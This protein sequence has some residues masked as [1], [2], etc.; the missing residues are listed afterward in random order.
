MIDIGD[1]IGPYRITSLIGTGGMGRVYEVEHCVTK[2]IEA[3]KLLLPSADGAT[4]EDQQE[5]VSRFL[6]EIQVQAS[7]AHPNIAAVHHAFVE[8]GLL[9]MVMEMVRGSSLKRLIEIDPPPVNRAVDYVAQVLGAL[10]YAH[11]RGVIH[12]DIT[13]ANIIVTTDGVAKLTDFGLAKSQKDVQITRDGV[14][15]GSVHYMSPE[16]VRGQQEL[17][18]RS[19]LYS[20][21]AVLY[22]LITKQKV[23]DAADG[24][25]IMRA[26]V[27]KQ[28]APPS[29]WNKDIPRE[30]NDLVLKALAKDPI[31]RFRG[32]AE[33][34]QALEKVKP[35]LEKGGT[36]VRPALSAD[37]KSAVR[38]IPKPLVKPPRAPRKAGMFV[39]AGFA[40]FAAAALGFI[41]TQYLIPGSGGQVEASP[42]Q[43]AEPKRGQPTKRPGG[44][45]KSTPPSQPV[46][47]RPGDLDW[48]KPSAND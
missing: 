42:A 1:T 5:H 31:Q 22:E 29:H 37:G 4:P 47:P 35:M 23:F 27:E 30:L 7:L 20:T 19:D 45:T 41:A 28:P 21:G 10:E 32:A 43:K 48:A 12:R 2:R 11:R 3:M 33:F 24:F 14:A 17:D 8:D 40:G 18:Y 26:H 46:A 15:V 34:R 13:P 25:A 38:Q 9:V 44:K 36:A 39:A 6:R 16:Q